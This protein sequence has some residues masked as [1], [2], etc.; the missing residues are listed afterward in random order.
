MV[1]VNCLGAAIHFIHGVID[2]SSPGYQHHPW[3]RYHVCVPRSR[4]IS[5]EAVRFGAIVKGLRV[6]RNWTRKKLATRAG[7]TPQ[8]I[9]IV[10][11][12]GNVPSLTTVLELIEVLQGDIE[13]VMRKLANARNPPKPAPV[14]P[15]AAPA[16]TTSS[17]S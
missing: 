1:Q 7:L 4:V 11:E 5:A 17:S 6:E 16:G 12:G 8:Y 3:M 10:E 2:R 14:A 13:D 15:A 9:A